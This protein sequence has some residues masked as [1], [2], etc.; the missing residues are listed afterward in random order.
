MKCLRLLVS[1]SHSYQGPAD[2]FIKPGPAVFQYQ[3]V[4]RK[5]ID[6]LQL[7]KMF[8]LKEWGTT[9]F[10]HALVGAY[11]AAGVR[12]DHCVDFKASRDAGGTYNSGDHSTCDHDNSSCHRGV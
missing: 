6:F 1:S 2:F 11:G 9:Y 10:L 7:K 5:A 8:F 12:L 3:M 4:C